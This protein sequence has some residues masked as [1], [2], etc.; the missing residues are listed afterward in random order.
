ML[1]R[2]RPLKLLIGSPSATSLFIDVELSSSVVET[3]RRWKKIRGNVM[4]EWRRFAI[5]AMRWDARCVAVFTSE[6][7]GIRSSW[8]ERNIVINKFSRFA[9][10]IKRMIKR[11]SGKGRRV[12][13]AV[14]KFLSLKHS[15]LARS[16]LQRKRIVQAHAVTLHKI[17]A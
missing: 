9:R 12:R 2:I 8:V 11:S 14:W 3:I 4:R 16:H 15:L 10:M 13:N 6:E 5:A 17:C 1:E 7:N